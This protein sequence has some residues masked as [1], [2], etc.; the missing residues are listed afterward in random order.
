MVRDA[1]DAWDIAE[2]V[3]ATALGT[4]A[5]RAYEGDAEAPLFSDPFAHLFLEAVAQA[6]STVRYGGTRP[7][8][9]S[10]TDP[11]LAEFVQTM[12]NFAASRTKFFD[13]FA[14]TATGS[15]VRQFVSLAAGL[16]TRAWRLE[17]LAGAAVFEIDQPGVLGF[18]ADVLRKAAVTPVSIYVPVPIDLRQDWPTKLRESGFDEMQPT[19]WLIEGL[20]PYLPPA[21]QSTLFHQVCLL[22]APGSRIVVDGYRPEFFEKETLRAAFD[23]MARGAGPEG[24]DNTE[25]RIYSEEL[26]FTG[27]RIDVA[28]WLS[29]QGW[30]T[31][32]ERSIEAMARLGRP[33]APSVDPASLGSDFI[34]AVL[35]T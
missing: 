9:F 29:A 27:D 26:F 32:V 35:P 15:G 1:G 19:G 16:D 30:S 8:Q 20:L 17:H 14:A 21:A 2:S 34:A 6:G 28:E 11:E 18:K 12:T 31:T 7:A 5:V 10:E 3:G 24:S 25:D 33:A 4:A 22:S 23:Q 13:D